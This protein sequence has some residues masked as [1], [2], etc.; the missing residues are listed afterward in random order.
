[1]ERKG[2][3]TEEAI[4]KMFSGWYVTAVYLYHLRS[5]VYKPKVKDSSQVNSQI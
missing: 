3:D 4:G 1:M 2:I 5:L